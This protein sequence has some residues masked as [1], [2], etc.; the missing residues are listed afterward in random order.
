M[1]PE[2]N[3]TCCVILLKIKHE[4]LLYATVSWKYVYCRTHAFVCAGVIIMH[5]SWLFVQMLEEKNSEKFGLFFLFILF[6]MKQ[7]FLKGALM[8]FWKFSYMF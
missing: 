3:T 7:A 8:Q 2:H 6:S 1:P 5:L 4:T